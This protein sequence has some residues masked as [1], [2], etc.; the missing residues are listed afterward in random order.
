[1]ASKIVPAF[2]SPLTPAAI[3]AWL[4]TCEDGFKVKKEHVGAL[5]PRKDHGEDQPE[6]LHKIDSDDDLPWPGH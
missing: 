5:L 1:M 6:D 3:E 2:T 4:G